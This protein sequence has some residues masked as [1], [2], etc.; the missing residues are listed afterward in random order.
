VENEADK[1][2]HNIVVGVFQNEPV[3]WESFS[4]HNLD[5]LAP[6]LG[7]ISQM[8]HLFVLPAV[9]SDNAP[10]LATI[11]LAERRQAFF[12]SIGFR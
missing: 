3:T 8:L 7:N 1:T 11:A 10:F 5:Y 2:Y 4:Q 9:L 12:A 6:H